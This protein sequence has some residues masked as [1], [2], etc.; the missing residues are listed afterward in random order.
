MTVRERYA[1]VCL[2]PFY[3]PPLLKI[4]DPP[5]VITLAHLP[6]ASQIDTLYDT[7]RAVQRHYID[8]HS[9]D[10]VPNHTFIYNQSPSSIYLQTEITGWFPVLP[11]VLHSAT[12]QPYYVH[13]AWLQFYVMLSHRDRAEIVSSRTGAV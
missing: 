9:N 11:H 1:T 7:Y 3:Q 8:K 4:L 10:T 6:T 13:S 12:E 2:P 5:L